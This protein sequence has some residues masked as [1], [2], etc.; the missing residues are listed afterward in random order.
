MREKSAIEPG[1]LQADGE[2]AAELRNQLASGLCSLAEMHMA[3]EEGD[4]DAASLKCE[5]LLR[6]ARQADARSPEPLQ[7]PNDRR[8]A[9]VISQCYSLKEPEQ[10]SRRQSFN[11]SCEIS[12]VC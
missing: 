2:E 11:G 3:S 4:M 12:R 9:P 1:L 10:I 5:P 7:V 8:Y 6:Q